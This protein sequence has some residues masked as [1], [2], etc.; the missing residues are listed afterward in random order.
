MAKGSYNKKDSHIK[1]C[2]TH[3][4]EAAVSSGFERIR[5]TGGF[6]DFS[7]SEM[8][9]N[10]E[11]LGKTL[12]LPLMIAPLTGG[13]SLSRRIN[14]RLAKAAE[15]LGLA[16]AVGSQKLMLDNLAAPDSYLLRD[17]AP[18][19]PLL[20]NIGLVHVKRGKEYL[21]RAVESIEAD[22]LILYINPI[23]E[24]LQEGG[25]KNFHGLL[26][27]LEEIIADFPYPILLKEVGAGIPESLAVWAA[28]RSGIR[29]VDVA[30]LG[31]TNWARI[32]GLMS[33][34]DYELYE[35][36]GTETSESI[37]ATRRH[38]RPDQYLVA[39]GGIRNGIEMAKALAMGAH[40][41]SMALPFLRWA[42]RSLEDIL[43]GVNRTE[44]AIASC[45]VVYGI[46]QYQRISG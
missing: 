26:R 35:S 21:L 16:M 44:K 43:Q 13:G 17:I 5:L 39:S 22:G 15:R 46:E 10:G 42:S 30:G 38:L 19:I 12:S 28:A 29:G 25:E 2:L 1:A 27:Q 34:Q 36:L 45:H 18:H 9:F 8:N 37:I 23:Q 7:F 40:L 14:R 33:D 20:A 41:V 6:P 4:V 11:F 32:E 3:D 24:A 31:G